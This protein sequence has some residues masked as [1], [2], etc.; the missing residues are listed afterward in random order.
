AE[1]SRRA[2]LGG[3]AAIAGGAGLA[4]FA[5]G[6]SVLAA[7]GGSA[8]STGSAVLVAGA[9]EALGDTIPGLVYVTLDAFA[10]DVAGLDP[11]IRRLY[12]ES[13]PTGMQPVPSGQQLY[14]PLP[15]PI[16][17]VVK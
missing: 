17:S 9:P 11:T 6:P 3:V 15:I 16:G 4:T 14:A 10:F 13:P 8:G 2:L 7:P 12:Q 5:G 1:L